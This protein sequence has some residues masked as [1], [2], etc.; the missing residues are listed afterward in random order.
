MH[1][2]PGD[3]DKTKPSPRGQS[4]KTATANGFS[5]KQ[6]QA[7]W[8]TPF[9]RA[10]A[11]ENYRPG[12]IPFVCFLGTSPRGVPHQRNVMSGA[13]GATTTSAMAQLTLQSRNSGDSDRYQSLYVCAVG[14]SLPARSHMRV[15][16]YLAFSINAVL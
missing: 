10:S 4:P 9:V 7:A 11:S 12:P 14:V 16:C 1:W 13:P 3:I 5:L 8:S 2:G 15:L 6:A